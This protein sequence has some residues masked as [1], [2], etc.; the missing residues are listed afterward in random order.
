ML[1]ASKISEQAKS[2]VE[3][4][5]T[6]IAL[7]FQ[8]MDKT[9]RDTQVWFVVISLISVFV[10]SRNKYAGKSYMSYRDYVKVGVS[11]LKWHCE[12]WLQ[13]AG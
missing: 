3:V 4:E 7:A 12:G 10:L 13:S 9:Q 8:L 6:E 11:S 1:D 5:S 2:G